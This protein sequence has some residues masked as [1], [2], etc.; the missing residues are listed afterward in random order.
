MGLDSATVLAACRFFGAVKGFSLQQLLKMAMT[1]QYSR[2]SIIFHEGDEAAGVFVVGSG[3]VRVYKSAPNGKEHVLHL[4]GPGGT[5]AEVAAI[6]GFNCP[7]SAEAIEDTDCVILPAAQFRQALRESHELCLQL[8]GSMAGWV[9]H[10]V[11]QLEDIALRDAAGRVA[12]YLLSKA[13][14]TDGTIRLPSL[15]RHLASHLNLTSE[16]LSRTL[17]RLMEDALIDETLEQDLRVINRAGLE[18]LA[19]GIDPMI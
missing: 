8:M 3:M 9:K 15:K 4:V 1:R 10:L 6:A 14:Q 18:E 16:T 11:G 5:F 7:A 12:R 13:D 2:G 17:R 19:E